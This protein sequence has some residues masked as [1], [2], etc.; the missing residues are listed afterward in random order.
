MGCTL[1]STAEKTNAGYVETAMLN[2]KQRL[3]AE[4]LMLER[5][6]EVARN[7]EILLLTQILKLKG[8]K[9]EAE[10]KPIS[11]VDTGSPE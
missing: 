4:V 9:N 10:R 11:S 3:R 1:C 7:K 5:R 8:S 6:L 2:E